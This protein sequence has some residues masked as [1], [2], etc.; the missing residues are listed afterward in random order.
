MHI[1]QYTHKHKHTHDEMKKIGKKPKSQRK[2][3]GKKGEKLKKKIG[4]KLSSS[5][6][7]FALYSV[8]TDT[9]DTN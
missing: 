2:R 1:S 9:S 7:S 3:T 8:H 6:G 5:T 4:K